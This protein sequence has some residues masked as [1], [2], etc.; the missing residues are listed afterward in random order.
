MP[1]AVPGWH[2]ANDNTAARSLSIVL[3]TFFFRIFFEIYQ[4][5]A[6]TAPIFQQQDKSDERLG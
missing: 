4:P 5:H 6:L 3:L 2:H 1:Q